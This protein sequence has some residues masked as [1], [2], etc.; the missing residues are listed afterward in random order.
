MLH[1]IPLFEWVRQATL[2]P[3]GN[4]FLEKGDAEQGEEGEVVGEG[5]AGA[6]PR[7]FAH[8]TAKPAVR[9]AVKFIF[10]YLQLRAVDPHVSEQSKPPL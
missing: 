6:L 2:L 3:K 8:G 1:V 9:T 4:L 5:H 7:A 10:L